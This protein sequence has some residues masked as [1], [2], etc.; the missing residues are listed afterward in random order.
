MGAGHAGNGGQEAWNGNGTNS[1]ALMKRMAKAAIREGIYALLDW[2]SESSAF[3]DLD[4][5]PGLWDEAGT[6]LGVAQM[7]GRYPNTMFETWNEPAINEGWDDH[8]EW[9]NVKP[10]H[11]QVI[12]HIRKWSDNIITL[13]NP[14]WNQH[15]TDVVPE[16]L[17][18]NAPGMP[19]YEG[20]TCDWA[21]E[22]N[23]Q[24][25]IH[26]YVIQ[27]PY[28]TPD[29]RPSAF[30]NEYNKASEQ[31]HAGGKGGLFIS[32]HGQSLSGSFDTDWK[33]FQEYGS[34]LADPNHIPQAMWALDN[35]PQGDAVLKPGSEVKELS[36]SLNNYDTDLTT[37][38]QCY[39]YSIW[40]RNTADKGRQ[41]QFG[42]T[43]AGEGAALEP[44][45]ECSNLKQEMPTRVCPKEEL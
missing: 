16:L 43:C 7:F 6:E 37:T 19:S 18:C 30:A 11:A 35:L 14:A 41:K 31:L 23:L 1:K 40:Q 28:S 32:E 44:P 42:W 17:P 26:Y 25:S 29:G 3:D 15:P 21:E 33:G 13:G 24:I 4:K 27:H 9:K 10:W 8:S 38:G 22:K 12:P 36:V 34:C 5:A 2:H 45:S 39:M 20:A